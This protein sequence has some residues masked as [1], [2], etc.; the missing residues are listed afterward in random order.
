MR[1]AELTP[2]APVLFRHTAARPIAKPFP[3]SIHLIEIQPAHDLL[4]VSS[5]EHT[6]AAMCY[7]QSHQIHSGVL[8]V[9][10]CTQLH[11]KAASCAGARKQRPKSSPH[12]CDTFK[13]QTSAVVRS[14]VRTDR[15]RHLWAHNST[16][17]Q[18]PMHGSLHPPL[19]RIL[20]RPLQ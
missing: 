6:I 8:P 17:S 13:H 4:A 11:A 20:G 2:K 18:R 7:I 1:K 16:H 3:T 9:R 19:R 5:Q 10:Q 14:C 15:L 12:L